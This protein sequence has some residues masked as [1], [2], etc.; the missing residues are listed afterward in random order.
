MK[1]A[2]DGYELGRN[3]KGVGRVI[4][5]L[6]LRLPDFLPED[7]ILIYTKERIGL[8]SRSRADEHVL[9]GRGGYLRWQ[10]GPFR[11]A[12][13]KAE[14]DLLIASNYVLPLICPWNSLLFE[15]DIS[16][17]A[18]PEWYPKKY[19][20]TRRCLIKRSLKRADI[21]LVSA[22][23]VG[24][25]IQ[26]LT[27]AD[28]KKIRLVGYGIEDKFRRSSD[29]R[30]MRWREEK[31][32]TG[33]RVI[34]FLGSIFKR[35]HV[36]ELIRAVDRLRREFPDVVL[37]L[38]GEDFGVFGGRESSSL[39]GLEWI[40]WEKSLPEEDLPVFYSSLDAFAYLSEYEGFGF[41]PLEALACGTPPVL[42]DGSSLGEVFAGLAIMV[43]G[44]DEEEVAV[45]LRTALTEGKTR[46]A[47]LAEFD[48][49]R[50]Q[51]SWEAAARDLAGLIGEIR[52]R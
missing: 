29:D 24:N 27:G 2:F 34:G 14:P 12:L 52:N 3:A 38:I 41:P 28:R 19:S 50:P 35:R 9:P 4:H 26:R 21:V 43:K 22:V 51:F 7:D 17:I 40:R 10:N 1:I 25:E 33:K 39:E 23:F 47:L 46:S 44:P 45:A 16:V 11:K 36:P 8:Y 42:L 5:N 31:G 20:L 48:R 37:Y 49:R 13:K 6:L 15:H 30:R 32:L 18:H